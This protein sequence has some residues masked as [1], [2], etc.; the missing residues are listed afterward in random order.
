MPS[1]AGGLSTGNSLPSDLCALPQDLFSSFYRLLKTFFFGGTGSGAPPNSN[2]EG[3]LNKF[4]RLKE[5]RQKIYDQWL[6][7]VIYDLVRPVLTFSSS[8]LLSCSSRRC[9]SASSAFR[10]SSKT[11]CCS[12][13]FNSS[14]SSMTSSNDCSTVLPTSTSRIG[15]TSTSK[16]NNY[17]HRESKPVHMNDGILACYLH[18]LRTT[19]RHLVWYCMVCQYVATMLSLPLLKHL[20]H[21]THHFH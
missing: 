10:S 17:S 18:S 3:V 13:R 1:E 9:C 8:R 15:L 19:Q 12:L 2:L 6:K 21:G 11:L 14:S 5:R 16:S 4:H 20:K 7:M